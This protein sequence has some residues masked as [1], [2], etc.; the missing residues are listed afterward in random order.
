MIN[1]I[2]TLI[3]TGVLSAS[4][5][6]HLMDIEKTTV[7]VTEKYIT[8]TEQRFKGYNDLLPGVVVFPATEK[9]AH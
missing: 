4:A 7:V 1:T 2:S 9:T 3:I 8:A 6:T 5:A